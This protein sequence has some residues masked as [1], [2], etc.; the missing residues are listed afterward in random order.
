MILHLHHTIVKDTIKVQLG[1][2]MNYIFL[3][4]HMFN[5]DT[6]TLTDKKDIVGL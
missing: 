6:L 1:Y 5:S 4:F 3:L 2:E